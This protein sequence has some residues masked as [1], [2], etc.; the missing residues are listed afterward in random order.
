MPAQKRWSFEILT[1]EGLGFCFLDLKFSRLSRI[2]L[3]DVYTT[4]LIS[5]LCVEVFLQLQFNVARII[6]SL[7]RFPTVVKYLFHVFLFLLPNLEYSLVESVHKR[8]NAI[9]STIPDFHQREFDV[10]CMGASSY[11]STKAIR[12]AQI[13]VSRLLED[14]MQFAT[15]LNITYVNWSGIAREYAFVS[16][17]LLAS[18]NTT[19]TA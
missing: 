4:I 3:V 11:S 15:C 6:F 1:C 17:L 10:I 19:L 16:T 14:R 9:I 13:T 2:S 5:I 7:V 8:Y 18:F 12:L